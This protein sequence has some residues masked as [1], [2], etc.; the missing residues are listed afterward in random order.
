MEYIKSTI[1]DGN[2]LAEIRASA[3]KPSLEFLGR[4]DENRVRTRFLETF[5][6]DET[7]KIVSNNEVLGF[8]VV[9]VKGDHIFLDHLYIEPKH[10]NKKIGK[11]VVDKVKLDA[12]QSRLPIRL[13]ALR[14][15]KSNDFY[16]KNGF[17]K[18][19]EDEFDVYYEYSE[20]N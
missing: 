19:H 1:S 12:A 18:T 11:S 7:F 5:V 17:V 2:Q 6:S 20:R 14:G 13:G 15:S 8:Y 4:F 9:R 16:M 10:Q 3:M